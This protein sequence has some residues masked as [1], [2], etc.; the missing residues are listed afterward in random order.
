METHRGPLDVAGI[1][2]KA[3]DLRLRGALLLSPRM[4]Y[5]CGGTPS[6]TEDWRN[7]TSPRAPLRPITSGFRLWS[8]SR[9]R[10]A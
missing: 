10:A 6:S 4:V 8:T 9:L 5:L 3:S 1:V 7:E 2:A